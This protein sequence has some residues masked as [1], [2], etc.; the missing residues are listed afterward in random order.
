MKIGRTLLRRI[1]EDIVLFT[2]FLSF[3]GTINQSKI[4]VFQL[5]MCF[6]EWENANCIFCKFVAQKVCYVCVCVRTRL[7]V[8]LSVYSVVS[9]R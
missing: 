4:G 6:C 7:S 1:G 2:R 8:H 9:A 3:Y 5:F